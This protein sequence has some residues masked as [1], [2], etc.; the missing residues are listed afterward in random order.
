MQGAVMIGPSW[1]PPFCSPG[2]AL[3]LLCS[4]VPCGPCSRVMPLHVFFISAC[5]CQ[6]STH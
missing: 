1:L 5:I 6:F 4:L 2:L 3:L